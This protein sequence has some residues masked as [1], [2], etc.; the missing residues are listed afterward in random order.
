MKRCYIFL[1]TGLL[2]YPFSF[3]QTVSFEWARTFGSVEEDRGNA[4]AI[5]NAGNSYIVGAFR[6]TA[7]FDPGEGEFTLTSNGQDDG[8]VQKMDASGNFE[9]AFQIG[10]E[11]DLD[12][13]TSIT[14]D[15]TGDI[16]VT[17]SFEGMVDFDPGVG[18]F[19][20]TSNGGSDIFIQKLDENGNLI[21]AEHFGGDGYEYCYY[22][23]HDQNGDIYLTGSINS[24]QIDF[25]PG[26]GVYNLSE[27]DG[28]VFL[29]K[30]D[31]SDKLIWARNFGGTIVPSYYTWG[32]YICLD[33]QLNVYSTGLF[34][35]TSDFD[36]G[37]GIY[38]LSSHGSSDAFI[39]KLNTS[40]NFVWAR[41][42]GGQKGDRG[43]SI[44]T[45]N[46]GNLYVNGTFQGEVDFDPGEGSFEYT[47]R[48]NSD[49]FILKLDTAAEFKWARHRGGEDYDRTSPLA[50]DGNNN[51]FTLIGLGNIFNDSDT[52]YIEKTSSNGDSL[53]S[54]R[55]GNDGAYM[56][57][58]LVFDNTGSLF[59]GGYFYD[60][61]NLERNEGSYV[62]GSQGGSDVFLM[63][64]DEL[65]SGIETVIP[66]KME[67]Y[68][69]P[70]SGI[71]FIK[72]SKLPMDIK[73]TD[74]LGNLCYRKKL[75]EPE[76]NISTLPDGIYILSC[77]SGDGQKFTG[78]IIL[79]K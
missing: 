6:G 69:N 27:M 37:S 58:S 74:C 1:L 24:L 79:R 5:D 59:A 17:G 14:T 36:P 72:N 33:D 57:G 70:G 60:T 3:A 45:D 35:S 31:S 32:N 26:D 78:K 20:L 30:L 16:Y 51:L 52:S 34:G 9:W 23:T 42:I 62:L 68:P 8:F 47:G 48:G 40:G 75:C 56:S 10:A 77:T 39:L 65:I 43:G 12:R 63:K 61:I 53:W 50:I 64:M 7:D 49:I 19:D 25:D 55:M 76:L 71:I 28:S 67:I 21:W 41:G 15:E 4:L 44:I 46:A 54:I 22:I 18:V 29:L 11:G 73:I 66:L 2:F 38:N 13:A